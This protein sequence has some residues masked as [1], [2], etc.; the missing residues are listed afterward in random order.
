VR[1]CATDES[2]TKKREE[3]RITCDVRSLSHTV[4]ADTLHLFYELVGKYQSLALLLFSRS[5][6]DPEE[7]LGVG[8]QEEYVL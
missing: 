4:S 8:V 3:D 5:L 2:I 7:H 1:L 6:P